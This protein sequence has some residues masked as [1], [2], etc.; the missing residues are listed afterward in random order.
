M[1]T[2]R[3]TRPLVL[4]PRFS[5]ALNF[6]TASDVS[7]RSVARPGHGDVRARRRRLGAGGRG[8]TGQVGAVMPPMAG[9]AGTGSDDRL[10]GPRPSATDNRGQE[11]DLDRGAQVKISPALAYEVAER[12]HDVEPGDNDVRP[13]T[14]GRAQADTEKHHQRRDR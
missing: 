11:G 9:V 6:L 3:S 8:L 12:N 7:R 10:T 2:P 1:T 4:S 5:S 14:H 13:P